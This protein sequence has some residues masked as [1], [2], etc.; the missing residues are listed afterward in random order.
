MLQ[1]NYIQEDWM[2]LN[3]EIE[4]ILIEIILAQKEEKWESL[5]SQ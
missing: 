1:E 5:D 2:I 3:F 4:N